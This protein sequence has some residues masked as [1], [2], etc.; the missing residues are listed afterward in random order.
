MRAKT[1][2]DEID[3]TILI[4]LRKYPPSSLREI[5]RV[6]ERSFVTVRQRL[7]WLEK[8][9]YIHQAPHAPI[10][11]PRSKILSEK[12]FLYLEDP[13]LDISTRDVNRL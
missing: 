11:S 4:E 1:E 3:R 8:N 5:G 7:E 9:G 6:I 13:H 12:G 2:L 10:G